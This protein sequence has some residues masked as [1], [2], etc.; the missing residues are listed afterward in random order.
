MRKNKTKVNPYVSGTASKSGYDA[1]Y[2]VFIKKGP[3]S[4]DISQSRGTG[5]GP[6]TDINLSLNIPITS[7]KN[8][9]KKL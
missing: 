9:R 5:Y 8:K 3:V 2:G 4:V 7:K 1:N 6:E